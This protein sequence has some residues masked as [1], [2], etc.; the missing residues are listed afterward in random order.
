[1]VLSPL[2]SIEIFYEFL[3]VFIRVYP[4]PIMSFAFKSFTNIRSVF[5]CVHLCPDKTFF[6][7]A[8]NRGSSRHRS[9]GSVCSRVSLRDRVPEAISMTVR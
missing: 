3:S 9:I 1:V 2:N 4:R 7:G 8:Q 6:S 5:I